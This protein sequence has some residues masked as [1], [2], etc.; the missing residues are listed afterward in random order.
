MSVPP[1]VTGRWRLFQGADVS[2]TQSRKFL[3]RR[4]HTEVIFAPTLHRAKQ[5][6]GAAY[7]LTGL[8]SRAHPNFHV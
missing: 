5:S 7:S 2:L 8:A 6:R 4:P 3:I 1:A